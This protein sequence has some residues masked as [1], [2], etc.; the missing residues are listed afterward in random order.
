MLV[1][2]HERIGNEWHRYLQLIKDMTSFFKLLPKS[3]YD[4][5]GVLSET[6]D[7]TAWPFRTNCPMF[8]CRNFIPCKCTEKMF[9]L[10]L[11]AF[12]VLIMSETFLP[13]PCSSQF[14]FPVMS[15]RNAKANIHSV[16]CSKV[17]SY[18]IQKWQKK[19]TAILYP[20]WAIKYL[21]V[22]LGIIYSADF[23]S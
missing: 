14:S 6:P 7:G 15:A 5:S 9:I 18:F 10:D 22:A 20:C 19:N 11:N 17:V 4:F 21:S 12:T 16:S 2:L 8:K 13:L 1:N 23:S 3:R